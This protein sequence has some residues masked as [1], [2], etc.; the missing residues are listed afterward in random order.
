MV[1][2]LPAG[3]PA[4]GPWRAVRT[5]ELLQLVAAA[6]S[7]PPG[8]PR[9]LAVDGR[10]G[11]GKSTLADRL[12][13]EVPRS[14]VVHTD[15]LAWRESFFDWGHLLARVLEPVR[16]GEPVRF[17]PPAWTRHGREG[18]VEIPAGLDL[19]LV[20]GVGANQHAVAPLA[21]SAIWVQA[22]F[23]EAKERGIERDVAAGV[24]GGGGSGGRKPS[25]NPE[26]IVAGCRESECGPV[27]W[28]NTAT[29]GRTSA[30][31]T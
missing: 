29:M 11:S 1:M 7:V 17:S 27:S 13:R 21:D 25:L 16:R 6:T 5:P 31:R 9:V 10:S 30:R 26:N 14:A 20:E 2:S 15:D 22:D 4:A 24:N 12:R 8:R 18:V 23:G 28:M 19:V 3:E